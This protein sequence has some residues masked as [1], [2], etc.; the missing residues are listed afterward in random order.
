MAAMA[1]GAA[2]QGT[3]GGEKATTGSADAARQN[4]NVILVAADG[5]RWQEVFR[6]MDRDMLTTENQVKNREKL[7]SEFDAETTEA[8]RERLM[9][10]LWGHVAKQGQIY[11]NR[12][13][14][15][16]ARVTNQMWFSYPGYN[17]MLTG[18]ADDKRVTSN[19]NIPNPNVTVFEW[20]SKKPG[21]DGKAAAFASWGVHAYIFN[22]GRCGFP[23]DAGG[24]QF[25]PP[26]GLTCGME[27]LNEVRR[28]IPFR[29]NNEAFD[30]MVFPMFTEYLK[31]QKPRAAFMG[32]IETD[33]YGHEG[34]YPGYL[35]AAHRVDKSLKELWDL[36]QSMPEYRDNTTIIFTCDHGRGDT[37]AG[38]KAWNSH[39]RKVEGADAIFL[40]AWGPDTPALGEVSG[41]G[42]ITQSQIAA[43]VAQALGYDYNAEH[44]KAAPPVDGV[45]K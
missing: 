2:G 30:G 12:D 40:A 16:V 18:H 28:Q 32:F 45:F 41:G 11:G 5:L 44:P 4:R 17:E 6:G 33:A 1:W 9:P 7:L 25:N 31:T 43:T 23:V 35:D 14:G 21:I 42:E 13:K 29:W 8:R 26:T 10:F 37:A 22:S 36:V 27:M 24:R 3:A 38:P 19:K 20:L 34:N 39:G 15:S